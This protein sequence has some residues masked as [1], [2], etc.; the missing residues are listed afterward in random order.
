MKAHSKPRTVFLFFMGLCFLPAGVLLA[1]WL[2]LPPLLERYVPPLV[3]QATGIKGLRLEVRHAGLFGVDLEAVTLG[4]PSAPGLIIDT[5]KIDFSFTGLLKKEIKRVHLSGVRVSAEYANGTFSIPGVFPG[6]PNPGDGI[7]PAS[8]EPRQSAWNLQIGRFELADGGIFLKTDGL[9]LHIPFDLLLY[10]TNPGTDRLV[11]ELNLRP[12]G[13]PVNLKADID[14]PANTIFICMDSPSLPLNRFSAVQ[15][16]A[17]GLNLTGSTA[18]VNIKSKWVLDPNGIKGDGTFHA[19]IVSLQEGHSM[20][21]FSEAVNLSGGFKVDIPRSDSWSFALNSLSTPE[22]TAP[23]QG[24]RVK[25]DTFRVSFGAPV[26]QVSGKGGA[27]GGQTEWYVSISDLTTENDAASFVV[28]HAGFRGT[29][30][31]NTLKENSFLAFSCTAD[32]LELKSEAARVSIPRLTLAGQF[33]RTP[34]GE[35]RFSGAAG[36]SKAMVSLPLTG[37]EVNGISAELPVRWPREPTADTGKFNIAS[38]QRNREKIGSASGKLREVDMLLEVEGVHRSLLVPGL[39]ITFA[40]RSVISGDN[41]PGA[42]LQYRSLPFKAKTP[43]D[44][45]RFIPG[46]AGIALDGEFTLAGDFEYGSCGPRSA[47]TASFL[48]GTLK[49]AD[50]GL[51]MEDIEAQIHFPD[52]ISFKS[53]P[54]QVI[55]FASADFGG[56]H[57]RKGEVEFQVE[58]LDSI[59]IEKTGFAW[60]NGHVDVH[61]LRITGG[62]QDYHVNLYCDR[63]NL[64]ELLEQFGAAESDGTGTVNGKIPIR[65]T[66][67][68]LL[69]DDGFLYSTPGHGG[70]IKIQGT[71]TL[72]AG[73]PPNTPQ[74][75]QMELAKEAL[76]SYKYNWA[77]LGITTEGEDLLL[78]LELD[79]KPTLPLPFIYQQEAGG[80]ARIGS[81]EKGSLFQGINMNINFRLPLDKILQYRDLFKTIN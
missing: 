72:L 68:K 23:V 1:V 80:F 53:D 78:R 66:R 61:A 5:A 60:C 63:L 12:Y 73:I 3:M 31:W 57:I 18:R 67:G 11:G 29:V 22:E 39:E 33:D 10:P 6:N 19:G 46:A 79:G 32:P 69:F 26:F 15:V 13:Q 75:A 52:L 8:E 64:A 2:V 77:T 58:S 45:G 40:G 38:I 24:I 28:P 25:T 27:S 74:F 70:T 62:E 21:S 30:S 37:I 4:D 16:L 7:F 35:I 47:L 71:E 54:K 44:L 36:L 20:P 34:A 55:R 56:I 50:A 59:F 17:K 14:L 76:K 65:Y 9:P 42:S 48:H 51:S 43:L 81:G 41:G 49:K